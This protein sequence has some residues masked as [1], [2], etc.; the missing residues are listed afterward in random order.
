MGSK[1]SIGKRFDKLLNDQH[2]IGYLF[3]APSLIIITCFVI[4]PMILSIAFSFM[5]FNIMLRNVKFVGLE[6]YKEMFLD[7]RVTGALFNT[8]Y[9][10]VFQV[11]FQVS[12]GLIFAV[13]IKESN[14]LNVFFRGTFFIPVICSMTVISIVWQFLLDNDIGAIAYYLRQ[15]GF[16]G[17]LLKDPRQAM[18]CVI[19]VSVWKSFGFSMVIFLAALQS[20]PASLYEAAAI[21]GINQIQ[22]LFKITI[23]M[24]LPTLGFV[25]IT[26]IIA[27]FQVFDQVYVMTNGGPIYKT[28]TM[29]FYIY[30]MAFKTLRLPYAATNAVFLFLIILVIS[31]FTFKRTNANND[32]F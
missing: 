25:C 19:A 20:I 23:P 32:A 24:I 21:E 26:A 27:S 1:L 13:M 31:L 7:E 12:L 6:N 22:K 4:L 17:K 14:P 15:F 3:I 8:F 2:K 16:T 5:D 30:N 28:E 10:T 18:P 11:F 9:F 29:V